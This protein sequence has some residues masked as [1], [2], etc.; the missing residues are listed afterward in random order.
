MQDKKE[1]SRIDSMAERLYRKITVSQRTAFL[2]VIIIGLIAH[3]YMFTNKLP[4]YDDML[5]NS[6]GATFRLGRWFL[7][8]LGAVAYHL[9]LVYSLPWVNGI[10]SLLFLA[11]AAM[12]MVDV[13]NI[14]NKISVVI[15]SGVFVAF[16]SWT[17][18]FFFMFTAPYYALAVLLIVLSIYLNVKFKYGYI[19]GIALLALSLGIYQAYLPFA[20]TFYV[21]VLILEICSDNGDY[22]L[23]WKKAFKYLFTILAGVLLYY[24]IMKLSLVV[25]KQQLADYKGV[26]QM[27]ALSVSMLPNLFKNIVNNGFGIIV[28][29]NL[30]ISYNLLLKVGYAWL[31]LV[32]AVIGATMIIRSAKKQGYGKMILVALLLFAFI[33]AINGIYII[34]PQEDAVYALMTF[35]YSFLI[36]FPIVLIDYLTGEKIYENPKILICLEYI[37]VCVAGIMI[38]VYCHFANAEYFSIQLSYEQATSYYTTLITQIKETEGYSDKMPIVFVGDNMKIEDETL[39]HNEIMDIFD[40]SGR[41]DTLVE[42]Y[43]MQYLLRYYCGFD[44]EY[45]SVTEIDPV[46]VN[47]MPIYP[48]DGSIKIYNNSVIVKLSE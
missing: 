30:E 8:L 36:I 40:M 42:S 45:G 6:F 19:F 38:A 44:P 37:S 24:A 39:Y 14:K 27:G 32:D 17:A 2:S 12:L 21:V 31:Y 26:G 4:N 10:L 46:I 47:G 34:C 18:T 16:P 35:A 48:E 13:L 1:I 15:I 43:T 20:A 3:L 7:W 23:I 9:D 5:I 25:T 41:D 28:N 33:I 11:V 22:I 29:N